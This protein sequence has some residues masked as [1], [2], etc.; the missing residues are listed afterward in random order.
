[1]LLLQTR[2]LH[3]GRVHLFCRHNATSLF[4]PPASGTG[5]FAYASGDFRLPFRDSSIP[6]RAISLRASALCPCP[7]SVMCRQACIPLFVHVRTAELLIG[8]VHIKIFVVDP[9]EFGTG[10]HAKQLPADAQ[11]LL[12]ASVGVVTWDTY[13][14]S[15]A[16]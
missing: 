13:S 4:S 5:P 15:N 14:C 2:Q 7:K 6:L 11:R 1:P 9:F 10:Q 12:D 16:S 3:S 8:I